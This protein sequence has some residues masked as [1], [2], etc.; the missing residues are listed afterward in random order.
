[1]YLAFEVRS[2]LPRIEPRYLPRT[3]FRE[4]STENL[5]NA[6]SLIPRRCR[7]LFTFC[8]PGDDARAESLTKLRWERKKYGSGTE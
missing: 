2:L 3:N 1:M 5:S 4:T 6:S 7:Y 8:L